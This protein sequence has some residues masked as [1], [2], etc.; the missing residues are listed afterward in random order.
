[1]GIPHYIE[2]LGGIAL[3]T[4]FTFYFSVPIFYIGLPLLYIR[5]VL[6]CFRIYTSER[7]WVYYVL[8]C[9]VLGIALFLPLKIYGF[10][11]ENSIFTKQVHNQ[12]IEKNNDP[13]RITYVTKKVC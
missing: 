2:L 5:V 4:A 3:I 13:I 6:S 7:M 8:F 12:R 11:E 9:I 10:Y 1:M